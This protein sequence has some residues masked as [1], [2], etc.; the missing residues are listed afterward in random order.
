MWDEHLQT[1]FPPRLAREEV[2]GRD[3]VLLDTDVAV[4]V[5]TWLS[6][7]GRLDQHRRDVLAQSLADLDQ[8]LAPLTDQAEREYFARLREL[9]ARVLR[10]TESSPGK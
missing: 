4:C 6:N 9:A 3:V 7:D 1:P 8:V 5:S 2:A 10:G